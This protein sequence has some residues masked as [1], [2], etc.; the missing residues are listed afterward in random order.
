VISPPS[1]GANDANSLSWL[2]L[3]VARL[4]GAA[5]QDEGLIRKGRQGKIWLKIGLVHFTIPVP[6]ATSANFYMLSGHIFVPRA[7]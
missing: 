3:F 2:I 5:S 6:P 7:E 1:W 4:L